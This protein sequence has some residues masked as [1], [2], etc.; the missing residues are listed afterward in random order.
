MLSLMRF[1]KL[2][3]ALLLAAVLTVPASAVP[4]QLVYIGTYTNAK[5]ARVESKGIY[6]FSLDSTTGKL[7]PMGL[8]AE[9]KS[10]SFLAIAPSK[11]FLYCVSEMDGGGAVGSF[12][13][14]IKTGKLT[15]LNQESSKGN[16]P[17]HVSVDRTGKTALVANYGSGHIASLPIREDGSLGPAASV[18]LQGPASQ[19]YPKRQE[20][21]HAHSINVSLD[22]QY[23]FSCD[24]GCDR[25]FAYKLD[26]TA[27]ILTPTI[28]AQV[29]PSGGPRHLSFHPSGKVAY[30]NNEMA[31]TV[32]ALSYDATKGEL[33]TLDTISTLPP[34][35]LV[36]SKL[37]TAEV[38]AHPS[39]KF[40]YVS[41]R[42][43]NSIA[44]YT[45]DPDNGK[46]TYM[47]TIPSIVET[48][49]NF[50]IDPTG[51]WLI[52]AGQ[53]SSTLAVFAIDDATGRLKP[54]GQVLDVGSPV[55][56]K[57]LTLE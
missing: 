46:L 20:G 50:G 16:G 8:A 21:P 49:R 56:V 25:V 18:H 27:S 34:G 52:A 38:Q 2:L 1:S 55:C 41:N 9:A 32:T 5:D 29:P 19:A 45:V 24:L 42:G 54:T 51:K 57:F 23:A 48:P 3:S 14:D 37:S 4:D 15:P 47:E 13:L 17:C 12:A 7:E 33:K 36:D 53:K 28:S 22:N 26:A 44:W 11:K 35:T 31:M 43:H 39:G 10:P 6:V 40:V 30:V